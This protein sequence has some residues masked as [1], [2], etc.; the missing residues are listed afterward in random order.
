MKRS[1]MLIF[2]GLIVVFAAGC[3][4]NSSPEEGTPNASVAEYNPIIEPANFVTDIDNPYS[5]GIF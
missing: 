1:I 4:D 5:T 3:V 2:F